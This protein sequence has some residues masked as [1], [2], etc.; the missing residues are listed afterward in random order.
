[1]P[2][3]NTTK[4]SLPPAKPR[5]MVIV[6]GSSSDND[7]EQRDDSSNSSVQILGSGRP[8]PKKSMRQRQ[9]A[10]GTLDGVNSRPSKTALPVAAVVLSRKHMLAA[11]GLMALLL[12][13]ITF[14]V[15]ISA[16]GTHS[17]P[18]RPAPA[19]VASSRALEEVEYASPSRPLV[20]ACMEKSRGDFD[21][22]VQRFAKDCAG[23]G[24][25]FFNLGDRELSSPD[26]LLQWLRET[27]KLAASSSSPVTRFV[28]IVPSVEQLSQGVRQALKALLEDGMIYQERI[29]EVNPNVRGLLLLRGDGD[30]K[31]LK[32]VVPHRTAHMFTTVNS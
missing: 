12:A 3:K 30:R 4:A 25:R 13:T 11:I 22:I 21:S 17:Q 31:W 18:I 27:T 28:W 5:E 7:D 20:G 9:V 19:C 8:T 32:S 15:R 2:P 6:D 26:D 23:T 1:M 29:L 16:A 24:Y 14:F 10:H